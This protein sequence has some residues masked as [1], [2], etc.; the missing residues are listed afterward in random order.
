MPLLHSPV[1]TELPQIPQ[2]RP[3]QR[4]HTPA[5]YISH[6]KSAGHEGASAQ[7]PDPE[8]VPRPVDDHSQTAGL[9]QR[10]YSQFYKS[11]AC[12]PHGLDDDI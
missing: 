7:N 3:D 1:K 5:P 10:L 11:R 2:C 6:R 12:L 8:K 4:E 9:Q